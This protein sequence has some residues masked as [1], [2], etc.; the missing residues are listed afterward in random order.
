MQSVFCVMKKFLDK[1]TLFINHFVECV[2][3][4]AFRIGDEKISPKKG[5]TLEIYNN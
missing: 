2:T 1:I 4:I 3:G 5:W